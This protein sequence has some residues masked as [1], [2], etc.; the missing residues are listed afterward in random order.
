[1]RVVGMD[2]HRSFAQVAIL[3]DGRVEQDPDWEALNPPGFRYRGGGRT[4]LADPTL[5]A[6]PTDRVPGFLS[7]YS[8][9]AVDEDKAEVFAYLMADPEFVDARVRVDPV[10]RAKVARMRELLAGFCPAINDQFWERVHRARK[11]P[12]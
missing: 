8:T 7:M 11:Q 5:T 1:M 10:V 9:S 6:V 12:G 3:A 4:A 2:I